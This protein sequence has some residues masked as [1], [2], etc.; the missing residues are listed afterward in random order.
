MDLSRARQIKDGR[1]GLGPVVYWMS[2]DQ[3]ATDN[4][5]LLFAQQ[6]AVELRR[7]LLVVFALSSSFLGATLRQYGFML[8]GLESM[9]RELEDLRIGFYLLLAG[10]DDLPTFLASVGA[11]VLVEDLDPLNIKKRWKDHVRNAVRCPVWEIDAHNVVPCWTASTR[12]EWAARTFRPKVLEAL[13]RFL[14]PLPRPLEHPYPC[15]EASSKTEASSILRDMDIDR[16]VC[17]TDVA[18]G[19]KSAEVK[20][21]SFVRHRL[22][23]YPED[24]NNPLL[25]GQSGL[26]PYLHFGQMASLRV[27][28][29]VQES[30]ATNEAKVAF[31][32]ELIVRRELADNFCHYCRD[33]DRYEGLP[34]WSRATLER[35]AS[36]ERRVIYSLEE[37][38]EGRTE[39]GLWNAMQREMVRRGRMPGYLRMYWAKKVL[40]WTW[41]PRE[42]IERLV[43]LN[44]RYELDGRDPNGYTGILW[45]FG[46]HDRP[47]KERPIY[48]TV[49]YMSSSGMAR[50]F[51]VEAYIKRG[52]RAN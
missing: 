5:A 22:D 16:K 50:K 17:E 8:R 35:H 2:R 3:R 13:P 41:T 29:E 14:V 37:L 36:D 6:R 30:E 47:W 26:S 51:D 32:E 15:K 44:N 24:R 18:P 40:E 31:F 9:A 7:P 39:D 20:L 42:A 45:C 38:E 25:N 33:H 11:A 34:A 28:L 1:E 12:Q 27:A 21:R 46:L 52:L 43:H 4:P 48:G 49:R 23:L 10:S 19:S